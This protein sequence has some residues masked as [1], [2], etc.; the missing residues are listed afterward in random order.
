V[1]VSAGAPRSA[2]RAQSRKHGERALRPLLRATELVDAGAGRHLE[3]VGRY[4]G[5][6]A[7]GLGFSEPECRAIASAC[8]LHDIGKLG[9]P[10]EILLKPGPLTPPERSLMEGHAA[11]GHRILAQ[12]GSSFLDLAASIALTH[13]EWFDGAG[14][15]HGL[16]EDEIPWPGRIAAVADAFDALTS[17]RVYRRAATPTE[18]IRILR[19]GAGSQFDPRVVEAF[20][21]AIELDDV[22]RPGEEASLDRPA[23]SPDE[24][25]GGRKPPS[26]LPF[27]RS[28]DRVLRRPATPL[29]RPE[30]KEA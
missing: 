11:I 30:T 22:P 16:G 13:H 25:F 4:A 19:E 27:Q 24:G 5:V 3:Q 12:S 17:D 10:D 18:A 29:G 9:V 14:Y 20:L 2:R 28:R 8:R 6:A 26:G 7:R 23:G 21:D 15:P 1:R